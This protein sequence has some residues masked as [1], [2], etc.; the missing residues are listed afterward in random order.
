M[1]WG[2]LVTRLSSE[3]KNVPPKSHYDSQNIMTNSNF[4]PLE[5]KILKN[6]LHLFCADA[7]EIL[8]FSE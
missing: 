7:G 2:P 4:A 8:N 6:A 5:N 3:R 1:N